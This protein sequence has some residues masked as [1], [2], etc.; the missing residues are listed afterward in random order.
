MLNFQVNYINCGTVSFAIKTALY[1]KQP[2]P[3]DEIIC[4]C[5]QC[6]SRWDALLHLQWL[7]VYIFNRAKVIDNS[8]PTAIFLSICILNT[9][10][11]IT[12]Q[13]IYLG[14][15][16]DK[17]ASCMGKQSALSIIYFCKSQSYILFIYWFCFC[18]ILF[19][20]RGYIKNR[21]YLL[22]FACCLFILLYI[23][24]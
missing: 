20:L 17:K 5:W 14:V 19:Y 6:K 15:W 7:K 16:Y 13:V 21:L 2:L 12:I 10:R 8:F 4:P 3:S 23:L 11:W 9:G 18:F 22:I 1:K 24:S